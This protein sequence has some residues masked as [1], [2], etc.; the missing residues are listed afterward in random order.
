MSSGVAV[1]FAA[2]PPACSVQQLFLRVLKTCLVGHT[3]HALGEI[4]INISLAFQVLTL[5]CVRTVNG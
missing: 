3:E 2:R 1:L 4:N 5:V